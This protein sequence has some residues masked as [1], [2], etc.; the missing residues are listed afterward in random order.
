MANPNANYSEAD[1]GTTY[2]QES[3]S[4]CE[5]DDGQDNGQVNIQQSE[6]CSQEPNIE[7]NT[8]K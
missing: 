6:L 2:D 5:Q 8:P 7:Q 1:S 3:P 4:S